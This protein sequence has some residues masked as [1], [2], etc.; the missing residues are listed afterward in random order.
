[1]LQG[2]GF[3][4][5][6]TKDSLWGCLLKVSVSEV[7]QG[8]LGDPLQEHMYR[9]S[10]L[11]IW[12]ILFSAG[13]LLRLVEIVSC[14]A[15]MQ[16]CMAAGGPLKLLDDKP[17]SVQP[18]TVIWKASSL[19]LA[20]VPV[21]QFSLLGHRQLLGAHGPIF[22]RF[23]G[24]RRASKP[25]SHHDLASGK[26]SIIVARGPPPDLKATPPPPYVDPPH[27]EVGLDGCFFLSDSMSVLVL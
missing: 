8:H 16:D 12:N 6:P 7:C 22:R 11:R 27:D 15:S 5:V 25:A 24:A 21:C 23:T 10:I 4:G 9:G 2:S 13:V 17:C 18:Y 3:W 20:N 14:R 26:S 1:M 19:E